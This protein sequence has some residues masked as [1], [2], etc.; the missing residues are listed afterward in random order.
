MIKKFCLHRWSNWQIVD[1]DQK[2]LVQ[3]THVGNG[4][5]TEEY[6]YEH[7]KKC[8]KCRETIHKFIA[9]PSAAIENV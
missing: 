8:L 3:K 7:E 1:N 9:K 6:L 4:E 5:Y 2:P